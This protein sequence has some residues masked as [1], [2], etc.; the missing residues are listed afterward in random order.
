MYS[1]IIQK[2]ALQ[3]LDNYSKEISKCS[4]YLHLYQLIIVDDILGYSRDIGSR[5]T[6][7]IP[8]DFTVKELIKYLKNECIND[9]KLCEIR[10][11]DNYL[12]PFQPNNWKSID[13][14]SNLDGSINYN[15]NNIRNSSQSRKIPVPY[16]EYRDV[17][18]IEL[19][20]IREKARNTTFE[21]EEFI[22][23]TDFFNYWHVPNKFESNNPKGTDDNVPKYNIKQQS[24]H[25]QNNQ[26]DKSYLQQIDEM[27]QKLNEKLLKRKQWFLDEIEKY[28]KEQQEDNKSNDKD[29]DSL[30]N[31]EFDDEKSI[32]YQVNK[33][34]KHDIGQ[35]LTID[36]EKSND[37]AKE[38]DN[39]HDKIQQDDN[40]MLC[41]IHF[42]KKS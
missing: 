34:T 27:E 28:K 20:K 42:P 39:N 21:Q 25:N 30:L 33:N 24:K 31:D 5:N 15:S 13:N 23:T 26:T 40:E 4:A 9:P 2:A 32:L 6:L 19:L 41:S 3:R 38:S 8:N 36:L 14:L 12:N 7:W 22:D 29:I 17:E 11:I 18:P 37:N 16:N 1:N 35:F 10:R